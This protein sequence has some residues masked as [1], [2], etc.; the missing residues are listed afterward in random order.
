MIKN[1]E[2]N[3]CFV[4]I[5][6]AIGYY[7]IL[8]RNMRDD[9]KILAINPHPNFIRKMREC[10]VLNNVDNI[11]IEESAVCTNPDM[12]YYLGPKYGSCISEKWEP[13]SVMISGKTLDQII[14]EREL[15]DNKIS[16]RWIFKASSLILLII[17]VKN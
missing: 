17:S 13:D 10:L 2:P 12:K 8:A 1:M 7:P 5:G 3:E 16:F 15:N 4:N 9:I 6:S 14:S 11:D